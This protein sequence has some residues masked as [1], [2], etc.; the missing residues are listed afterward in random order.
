MTTGPNCFN[1]ST[2]SNEMKQRAIQFNDV[3]KRLGDQSECLTIILNAS[4]AS[5]QFATVIWTLSPQRFYILD[6]KTNTWSKREETEYCYDL[7]CSVNNERKKHFE[8]LFGKIPL[9]KY[10]P[11]GGMA[12]YLDENH[13]AFKNIGWRDWSCEFIDGQT[14]SQTF[15]NG[16]ALGIYPSLPPTNLKGPA[17][18][19]FYMTTIHMR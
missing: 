11:Y 1:E 7:W 8:N 19:L 5:Y 12:K 16:L 15:R 14:F 6:H 9:N 13:S 18:Y 4:R 10:V 17:R 3:P 2:A